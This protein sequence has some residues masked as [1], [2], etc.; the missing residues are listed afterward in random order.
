MP[1]TSR[2]VSFLSGTRRSNNN[3]SAVCPS[4]AAPASVLPFSENR[5]TSLDAPEGVK[6]SSEK[7][8]VRAMGNS[9]PTPDA[10]PTAAAQR[11]RPASSAA[12]SSAAASSTSDEADSRCFVKR[13][14]GTCLG[15]AAGKSGSSGP[16][17]SCD[18]L[19][20][21]AGS[22]NSRQQRQGGT[23]LQVRDRGLTVVG[24][25]HARQMKIEELG[26]TQ[27]GVLRED[28]DIKDGSYLTELLTARQIQSVYLPTG[29][30]K[31]RWDILSASA[32][33]PL[34][35]HRRS[36]RTVARVAPSLASHRRS[37][38]TVAR[39]APSLA[40]HRRSR[41]A[42]A[43]TGTAPSLAPRCCPPAGM[44]CE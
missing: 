8:S 39:V 1:S 43:V 36:R 25:G 14:G 10:Q 34:A 22:F 9:Q 38:R 29:V 5:H 17:L 6:N 28:K 44:P 24:R 20:T 15:A 31:Q 16:R 26:M 41:R 2:C 19:T 27:G 7:F 40:P 33:P 12:A 37:R 13:R 42:R 32:A 21:A 4:T 3:K 18:L 11:V 23:L 35:P 30:F